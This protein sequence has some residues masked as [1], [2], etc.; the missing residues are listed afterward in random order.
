M[1][2]HGHFR[3][4]PSVIRTTGRGRANRALITASKPGEERRRARYRSSYRQLNTRIAV[5]IA[6]SA[7]THLKQRRP[8]SRIN[9]RVRASGHRS[10]AYTSAD[11]VARHLF[12]ARSSRNINPRQSRFTTADPAQRFIP[13][14]PHPIGDRPGDRGNRVSR[15]FP[16]RRETERERERDNGASGSAMSAGFAGLKQSRG[17]RRG[18]TRSR[19]SRT[20]ERHQ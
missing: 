13:A 3:A 17:Y 15:A 20:S 1:P 2:A 4:F 16:P 6:D 19:R 18:Q 9:R 7:D 14:R 11:P 12:C 10:R 8:T 5:Q